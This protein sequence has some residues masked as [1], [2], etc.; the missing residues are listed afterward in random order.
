MFKTIVNG[1][2]DMLT[3]FI[4]KMK[5]PGKRNL[6]IGTGINM[7]DFVKRMQN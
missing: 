3:T 2:L 6:S 5:I 4:V 7:L 1:L